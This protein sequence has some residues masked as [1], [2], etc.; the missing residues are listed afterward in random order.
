MRDVCPALS[1][2][3]RR[4]LHTRCKREAD[5]RSRRWWVIMDELAKRFFH[6]P[7]VYARAAELLSRYEA[8]EN[9]NWESVEDYLAELDEGET[10]LLDTALSHRKAVQLQ[11]SHQSLLEKVAL[12]EKTVEALTKSP[13]SALHNNSIQNKMDAGEVAGG[14][15]PSSSEPFLITPQRP[16]VHP[17]RL[18]AFPFRNGMKTISFWWRWGRSFWITSADRSR[19]VP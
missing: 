10:E 12:L 2:L 15:A 18:Q 13:P 8:V 11:Q 17:L 14:I 7:A 9:L 6:D 3:F 16:G 1:V 19:R 4:S 5:A